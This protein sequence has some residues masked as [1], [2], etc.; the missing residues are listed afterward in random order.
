MFNINV[1]KVIKN[2]LT[3]RPLSETIQDTLSW[4][5]D[6]GLD[7]KLKVGIAKDKKQVIINDYLSQK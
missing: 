4:I 5:N 3:F 7:S 1:E 6:R 2:S